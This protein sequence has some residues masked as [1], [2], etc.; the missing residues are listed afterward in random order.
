MAGVLEADT[1]AHIRFDP[2]WSLQRPNGVCFDVHLKLQI[3][4]EEVLGGPS[5]LVRKGTRLD[6]VAEN[7]DEWSYQ[8]GLANGWIP[9]DPIDL[10]YPSVCG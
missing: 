8:A 9:S 3:V 6:T 10:I 7:T 5:H 1:M 4:P 2:C